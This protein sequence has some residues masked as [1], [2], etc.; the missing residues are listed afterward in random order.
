[1]AGDLGKG[2]RVNTSGRVLTAVLTVMGL[3]IVADFASTR[4]GNKRKD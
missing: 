2:H 4:G 1:M 3:L